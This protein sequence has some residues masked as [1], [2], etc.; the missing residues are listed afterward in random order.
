[1]P[2]G[3][4]LCHGMGG[5]LDVLVLAAEVWELPQHLDA[6]GRN[7]SDLVSLARTTP[8]NCRPAYGR[9][10]SLVPFVRTVGTPPAPRPA[11]RP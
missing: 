10:T 4:T 2:G 6:A 8:W 1:M 3:L 9:A 7:A 5:P 11:H